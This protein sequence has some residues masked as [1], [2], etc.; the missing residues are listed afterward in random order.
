M[1]YC[2]HL[3]TAL[4]ILPHLSSSYAPNLERG[5]RNYHL[6]EEYLNIGGRQLLLAP[7]F[8]YFMLDRSVV[9]SSDRPALLTTAWKEVGRGLALL[10]VFSLDA[11][12]IYFCWMYSSRWILG[13]AWISSIQQPD[14][15]GRK[16]PL[17]TFWSSS[18]HASH[19]LGY[20]GCESLYF[21]IYCYLFIF[22]SSILI[23]W[24]FFLRN[25]PLSWPPLHR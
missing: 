24:F 15:L 5:V 9:G 7:Y 8:I 19:L 16:A 4:W 3:F 1:T 6:L 10:P 22:S 21:D 12:T 18:F 20:I 25:P 2:Y 11:Y 23:F 14:N 13:T 17:L